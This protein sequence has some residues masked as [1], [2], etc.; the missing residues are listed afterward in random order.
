MADSQTVLVTIRP[1]P[2]LR[3]TEVKLPLDHPATA[4]HHRH[5]TV[6]RKF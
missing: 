5:D 6:L 3:L 4:E 2:M 1:V